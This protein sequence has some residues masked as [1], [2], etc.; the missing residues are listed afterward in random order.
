[1]VEGVRAYRFRILG[2]YGPA[3]LLGAF[4]GPLT[5]CAKRRKR[6][7]AGAATLA[8]VCVG[9]RGADSEGFFQASLGHGDPVC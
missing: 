5:D 1:M 3:V 7:E 6:D 8:R 2:W 4:A 9:L